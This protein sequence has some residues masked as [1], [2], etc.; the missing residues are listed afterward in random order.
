MPF[1]RNFGQKYSENL[2][3]CAL[4]ENMTRHSEILDA[5]YFRRAYCDTNH[6]LVVEKV[7][8][9]LSVSKR[10]AQSF[11]VQRFSLKKQSQVE[12]GNSTK[13]TSL[14]GLKLW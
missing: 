4:I 1:K 13:L 14:T 9:P 11:D 7:R 12:V 2:M 5:R 10:A 8:E 6:Y 3:Q